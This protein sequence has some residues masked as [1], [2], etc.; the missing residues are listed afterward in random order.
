M[1]FPLEDIGVFFFQPEFDLD[2]SY[3]HLQV[4]PGD[5]I[6]PHFASS[7]PAINYPRQESGQYYTLVMVDPDAPSKEHPT[8]REWRHWGHIVVP[9]TY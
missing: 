3:G 6:P 2:I 9:F 4:K 8:N 5:V 7:R 1:A